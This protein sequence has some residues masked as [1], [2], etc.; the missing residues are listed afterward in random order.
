M[1]RKGFLC[2][3]VLAGLVVLSCFLSR[4]PRPPGALAHTIRP[5]TRAGAPAA[6]LRPLGRPLI[7]ADAAIP[8]DGLSPRC[9]AFHET[10]RSLDLSPWV[11]PAAARGLELPL[12]RPDLFAEA[13]PKIAGAG[14]VCGE[15]A[16][17]D[18]RRAHEALAAQCS[19]AAT[20]KGDEAERA[21]MVCFHFLQ[22]YRASLVEH[23]TRGVPVDEIRDPGIL[24]AKASARFFAEDGKPD[25][26]EMS[27]ILAALDRVA[28]GQGYDVSAL[29]LRYEKMLQASDAAERAALREALDEELARAAGSEEKE[30]VALELRVL[31]A[32]DRGDVPAMRE[33]AEALRSQSEKKGSYYLA[34]AEA[35]ARG[36]AGA[37]GRFSDLAARWSL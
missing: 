12:A 14:S 7:V 17:A 25:I 16:P 29:K 26:D 2:L 23:A 15:M 22:I 18:L 3:V 19:A 10:L 37:E 27:A 5:E 11:D 34:W 30:E 28:P 20:G 35:L 8:E 6:R 31:L 33:L 4:E 1:K 9:R 24:L 21:L 36:D 13:L 32:R